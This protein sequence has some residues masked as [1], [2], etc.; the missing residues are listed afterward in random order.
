M[1][2]RSLPLALTAERQI[3]EIPMNTK[4][5]F[6]IIDGGDFTERFDLKVGAILDAA[7]YNRDDLV[8]YECSPSENRMRDITEDCAIDWQAMY[9]AKGEAVP[10]MFAPFL[11]ADDHSSP[12]DDRAD[13]ENELAHER[14]MVGD[15]D[16]SGHYEP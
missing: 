15:R 1:T 2:M 6:W 9:G 14:Q 5:T 7:N 12:E 4:S 8:I 11:G 3:E 16:F 10:S 13:L